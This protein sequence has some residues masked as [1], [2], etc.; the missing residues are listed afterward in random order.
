MERQIKMKFNFLFYIIFSVIIISTTTSCKKQEFVEYSVQKIQAKLN[1]SDEQAE[2]LQHTLNNPEN[3]M[4]RIINNISNNF[5][6]KF[7]FILTEK[8]SNKRK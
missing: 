5:I 4:E 8:K 2:E 3:S 1:L 7:N 6:E